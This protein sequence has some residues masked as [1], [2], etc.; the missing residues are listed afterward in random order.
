M[1][2]LDTTTSSSGAND[3]TSSTPY[4]VLDS[5]GHTTLEVPASS[6]KMRQINRTIEQ[7]AEEKRLARKYRTTSAFFFAGILFLTMSIPNCVL[8]I[9]MHELD[10]RS[11][12]VNTYIFMYLTYALFALSFLVNPFLFAYNNVYLRKKLANFCSRN[13]QNS[14]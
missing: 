4:S 7:S 9:V 10:E 14:S 8:V 1:A 3:P 12:T 2:C 13:Q 5:N 6:V 11:I